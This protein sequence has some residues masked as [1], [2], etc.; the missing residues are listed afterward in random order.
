MQVSHVRDL[1]GV[2]GRET[3]EFGVLLSF[4]EPTRP[5]REEAASAGF[6]TS[7]WGKHPRIQLISVEELLS[8]KGIDYPR[9]AGVNVTLRAAPAVVRKVAEPLHLFAAS[10]DTLSLDE[11]EEVTPEP[12]SPSSRPTRKRKPRRT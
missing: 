4:E 12:A 7:P 5:M 3:A 11:S 10:G 1:L 9:T 6:Y 8:G 2:I